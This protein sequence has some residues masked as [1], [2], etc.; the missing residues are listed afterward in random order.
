MLCPSCEE[1]TKVLETRQFY[2][3]NF[4]FYYVERRRECLSCEKRFFSIE[5]NRDI[6]QQ[7]INTKDETS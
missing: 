7:Q 4:G 3:K 1:K 2:D 5:V 6:W